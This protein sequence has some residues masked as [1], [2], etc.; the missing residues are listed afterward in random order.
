MLF[1][2]VHI[3]KS[4][5]SMVICEMREENILTLVG[6]SSWNMQWWT[7]PCFKHGRH[8]G[9]IFEGIPWCPDMCCAMDMPW[10]LHMN[11]NIETSHIHI[12]TYSPPVSAPPLSL[13]FKN[14]WNMSDLSQVPNKFY[15]PFFSFFWIKEKFI[16]TEYFLW[17][18]AIK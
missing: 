1:T 16:L 13:I 5:V 2:V 12:L 15:I 14:L 17:I 7:R 9:Q 8:Q 6:H 11:M 4:R 3:C 18:F 10:L